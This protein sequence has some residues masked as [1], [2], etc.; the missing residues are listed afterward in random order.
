MNKLLLT[1]VITALAALAQGCVIHTTDRDGQGGG[2][3]GSGP[4]DV[5]SISAR[6][7]FRNMA[8]GASTLCPAGFDTV[9]LFALPVDDLGNALGEPA[10]DQLDCNKR[11]GESTDLVPDLYEVWIE[12]RS[13]DLTR[14]Y[15]QSLSRVLD[16]R[17]LDQTFSVDILNDGGFFQLSWELAGKTTNRPLE[18]SQIPGLGTIQ[19]VSVNVADPQFTYD[20]PLVCEDHTAV[21]GGL[22]EGSYNITIDA[23]ASDRSV[24]RITMLNNQQIVGPNGITD[25]GVITIPI[26][27]M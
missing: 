5:A 6:W 4:V 16:V 26:D 24:G 25:L 8:D 14:L 20:D 3:D 2:D 23:L 9:E 17:R 7:S 19:T 1:I 22:L 15:A 18:C 11:S 21:T 13:R 10:I 27:G 12:V